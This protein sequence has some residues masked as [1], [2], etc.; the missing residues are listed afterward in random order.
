MPMIAKLLCS[1]LADLNADKVVKALELWTTTF[2]KK[3]PT[4]ADI[5]ELVSPQPKFDYAVYQALQAK[6]KVAALTGDEWKYIKAYEQN[7]MKGL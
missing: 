6:C 1:K 4:P 7:A 3:L 5:R 2:G